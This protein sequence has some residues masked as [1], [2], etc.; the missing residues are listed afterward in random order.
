MGEHIILYWARKVEVG[1]LDAPLAQFG[2]TLG[3]A[4]ELSFRIADGPA[5][6]WATHVAVGLAGQFE[7][8]S[9]AVLR[10]LGR[11]PASALQIYLPHSTDSHLLA[12]R[13]ADAML[14]SI[15]G[16]DGIVETTVT[17]VLTGER[18]EDVLRRSLVAGVQGRTICMLLPGRYS[19]V[20]ALDGLQTLPDRDQ[21]SGERGL[22]A[23]GAHTLWY[24]RITDSTEVAKHTR[25]AR[26]A[27]ADRPEFGE[28]ACLLE[29]SWDRVWDN[30]IVDVDRMSEELEEE[31]LQVASRIVTRAAGTMMCTVDA[32]LDAKDLACVIRDSARCGEIILT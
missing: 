28:D 13:F 15:P 6:A 2:E 3:D 27:N 17:A 8:P 19:V 5:R 31:A 24:A 22:L 14:A 32:L 26:R 7:D 12:L 23:V 20:T 29:L 4:A 16:R 21:G 11:R 25:Y 10:R 9:L 1:A 30:G 18:L